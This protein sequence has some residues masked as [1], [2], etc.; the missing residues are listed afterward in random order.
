MR[1]PI[2]SLDNSKA[3]K[4]DPKLSSDLNKTTESIASSW[5]LLRASCKEESNSNIKGISLTNENK[6]GWTLMQT[7]GCDAI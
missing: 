4:S 3:E 7:S 2:Y 6:I 5:K 1:S